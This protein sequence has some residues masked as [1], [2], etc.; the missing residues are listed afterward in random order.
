MSRKRKDN[1]PITENWAKRIKEEKN[2]QK[3]DALKALE[4]CKKY[5]SEHEFIYVKSETNPRCL[6]RKRV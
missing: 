6:V 3:K 5:E 2:Q 1:E 4:L